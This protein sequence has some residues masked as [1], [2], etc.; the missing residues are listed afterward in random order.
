MITYILRTKEGEFYCGKTINLANR[1][2]CHKNPDKKSW[3]FDKNRT[4][5]I[6]IWKIDIDVEKD[7]KRFGV[8]KFVRCLRSFI[9][10]KTDYNT[11]YK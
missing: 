4:D 8:E 5:F 7:I 1:L 10:S 9:Q 2:L 6:L 3:F 11:Q